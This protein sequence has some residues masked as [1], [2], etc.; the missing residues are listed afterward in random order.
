[1]T[2]WPTCPAP[3][4]LPA[5][6]A[7]WTARCSRLVRWIVPPVPPRTISVAVGVTVK[8]QAKASICPPTPQK[9]E[10]SQ[11]PP[12]AS[13]VPLTVREPELSSPESMR[14]SPP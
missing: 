10:A 2:V 8:S 1:M 14:M 3:I 13:I 7:P 5:L 6:S 9:F 4:V 12:L 11:S